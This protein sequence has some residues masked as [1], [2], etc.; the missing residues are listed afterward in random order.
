[1]AE[2][3]ER[4]PADQVVVERDHEHYQDNRSGSNAWAIVAVVVVIL[5]LLLIFGRGM[6]GG[7]GGSSA[8]N[9]NITPSSSSGQ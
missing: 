6:F 4:R 7:S 3:V 2:V 1:M 5:A 9:V 8:P